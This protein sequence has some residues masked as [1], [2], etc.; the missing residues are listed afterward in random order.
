MTSNQQSQNSSLK[1]RYFPPTLNISDP[2]ED[3][4]ELD[5][6]LVNGL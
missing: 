1:S 2:A 6:D 3:S 5:D 4:N